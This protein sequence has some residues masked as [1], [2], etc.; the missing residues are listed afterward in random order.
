MIE[1]KKMEKTSK[2][3][4]TENNFQR[5][6]F[7]VNSEIT[8]VMLRRSVFLPLIYFKLIFYFFPVYLLLALNRFFL[9]DLGWD[10][11]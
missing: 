8:K 10:F 7:K 3:T 1:L 2:T 4:A 11:F 9:R 5:E 6:L